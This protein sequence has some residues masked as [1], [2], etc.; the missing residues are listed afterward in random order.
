MR[1]RL[2]LFMLA[3]GATLFVIGPSLAAGGSGGNGGGGGD[4]SGGRAYGGNGGTG[5]QAARV[6]T[7]HPAAKV[8]TEA[9]VR[10]RPAVKAATKSTPD[11]AA[12]A[13]A[14]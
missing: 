8:V 6:A 2:G 10:L 7:A 9:P 4:A 11:P 14:P 1:Q 12:L 13:K 3:L 5:G